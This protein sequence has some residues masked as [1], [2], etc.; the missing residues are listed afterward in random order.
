MRH[1]PT[2]VTNTDQESFI[3]SIKELFTKD[4]KPFK[5]IPLRKP[6]LSVGICYCVAATASLLIY[7]ILNAFEITH[8]RFPIVLPLGLTYLIY[9]QWFSYA[10][11]R[12]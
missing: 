1:R 9:R 4:V 11:R 7:T 12:A 5:T 6:A 3:I 8:I 2:L 10:E